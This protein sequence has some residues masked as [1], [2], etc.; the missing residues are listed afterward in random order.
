MM[1]SLLN[2]MIIKQIMINNKNQI[3]QLMFNKIMKMDKYLITLK[4][5]KERDQRKEKLL[6]IQNNLKNSKNKKH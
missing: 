2:Q 5:K 3:K 6:K 4:N 1:Q